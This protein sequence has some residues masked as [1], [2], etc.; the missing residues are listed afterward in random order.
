MQQTDD[1]FIRVF[2]GSLWEKSLEEIL[3]EKASYLVKMAVMDEFE[4]FIEKWSSLKDRSGKPLIVRNGYHKERSIMLSTGIT[5]IKIP[6]VLDRRDASEAGRLNFHSR[7]IPPYLR[8]VREIDEFIPYL[9][10]KGISSGDFSQV[11]SRLLGQEVSLSAT[12]V[13][14][15]KQKWESEY[16]EWSERDLSS[17]RYVYWW[18][19]G[20]YFNIRMEQERNCL[21]VIM[22]AM[23]DGK[24]ELV[25]IAEGPRESEL[26]W[27][28]ILMKLKNQ[29]LHHVPLLAV[30]D[31]AL[32]FW[33]ALEKE[34]PQTVPQRCWVHKTA[35]VL[36]KLPKSLQIEAKNKIYEIYQASSKADALKAFDEFVVLFEAKYPK[37]VS[38]LLKDKSATLAFYDFPAEHWR[39]IR[40]TNVIE[41]TF[42]TVRLRTDK[43]RGCLSRKTALSMVFKLAQAAEQTWQRIHH[44]KLLAVVLEGGRFIDGVQKVA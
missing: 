27:R 7:L 20:I 41:S 33:R 16:E 40:S 2:T 36:D 22:G 43:T 6:R 13:S 42:A 15:L 38:C 37:A 18:V 25:S 3:R 31:G 30:G 35:N 8:R 44:Y 12:T 14:R 32:G 4:V 28:N 39:H 10:L 5:R 1:N 9:Y 23:A 24:K 26:S 34:Y 19:D 11:L 21:L 29:G 17:K